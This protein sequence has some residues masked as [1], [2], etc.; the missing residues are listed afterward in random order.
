MLFWDRELYDPDP[1]L[2]NMGAQRGET[3]VFRSGPP[4]LIQEAVYIEGTITSGDG[5]IYSE[6]SQV[7]RFRRCAVR[8]RHGAV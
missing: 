3:M 6:S 8:R 4:H 2:D 1:K 5:Q 7:T